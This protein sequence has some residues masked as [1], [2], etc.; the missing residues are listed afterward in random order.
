LALINSSG[1]TV[2]IY[3]AIA[4]SHGEYRFGILSQ[5]YSNGLAAM[6]RF[7]I[8]LGLVLVAAGVLRPF[9]SRIGLGRLP[10]DMV[11][12]RDHVTS[13]FP[14]VTCLVPSLLPSAAFWIFNR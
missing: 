12:D 13:Y 14:I 7:V 6:A 10:G 4:T 8:V 11:V 3:S 2:R 1:A 5:I 9:L